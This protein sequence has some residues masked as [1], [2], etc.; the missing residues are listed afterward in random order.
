[1][2][3]FIG[4]YE[5]RREPGLDHYEDYNYFWLIFERVCTTRFYLYV[6]CVRLSLYLYWC[7]PHVGNGR[8]FRLRFLDDILFE[9]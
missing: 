7:F 4:E 5:D 1:M 2:A 6:I 3:S 9:Q 8:L